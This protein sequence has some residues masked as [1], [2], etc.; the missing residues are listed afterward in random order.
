MTKRKSQASRATSAARTA[1]RAGGGTLE[2]AVPR[3]LLR[4]DTAQ[5]PELESFLAGYL[6]EDFLDEYGSADGAVDAFAADA[7]PADC[8]ALAH[9]WQRFLEAVD[10]RPLAEIR[11]LLTRTFGSAWSPRSKAELEQVTEAI[12]RIG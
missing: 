6:H 3:T 10:T 2:P 9:E 11:L 12:S 1:G 5:Y 7:S 8:I 4:I